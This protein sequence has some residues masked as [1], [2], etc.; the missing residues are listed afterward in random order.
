MS[1][2]EALLY[3]CPNFE[4]AKS[5]KVIFKNG[6]FFHVM[7]K[8]NLDQRQEIKAIVIQFNGRSS[9]FH[10]NR[11]KIGNCET[12]IEF[13]IDKP[14]NMTSLE[15]SSVVHNFCIF[16]PPV[17]NCYVINERSPCYMGSCVSET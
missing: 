13:R 15:Q 14:R 11:S 1:E 12:I 7:K 3:D 5:K 8:A 10:R 16:Y 17:H 2:R 6:L 4:I 9:V